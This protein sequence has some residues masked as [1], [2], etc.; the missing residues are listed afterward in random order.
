MFQRRSTL[1]TV[2]ALALRL[3]TFSARCAALSL[4]N[5][6]TFGW[7]MHANTGII[8]SFLQHVIDEGQRL[9]GA[10]VKLKRGT[11]HAQ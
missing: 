11:G 2:A 7:T 6:I 5:S 4:P 3:R 10:R 8:F 9:K 1:E